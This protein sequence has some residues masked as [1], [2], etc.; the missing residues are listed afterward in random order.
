MSSKVITEIT[1]HRHCPGIVDFHVL[2]ARLDGPHTTG[3]GDRGGT[4]SLFDFQRLDVIIVKQIIKAL[5]VNAVLV[6]AK[7]LRIRRWIDLV[8][9]ANTLGTESDARPGVADGI[10]DV[11]LFNQ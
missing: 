11:G 6:I 5:G 1:I 3:V 8:E 2:V 9:V 7:V 4:A 10:L